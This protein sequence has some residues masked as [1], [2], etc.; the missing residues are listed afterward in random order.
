MKF[1]QP[2]SSFLSESNSNWRDLES[3]KILQKIGYTEIEENK[4]GNVKIK[5][6]EGKEFILTP[7][8]Y[9][10]DPQRYGTSN[11]IVQNYTHLIK[12]LNIF[13][14]FFRY[15]LHKDIN[16]ISTSSPLF[17]DATREI[18]DLLS[19]YIK[20]PSLTPEQNQFL[21]C[22]VDGDWSYDSKTGLVNI[23]GS[24]TPTKKKNPIISSKKFDLKTLEGLKFGNVSKNFYLSYGYFPTKKFPI[25]SL[26]GLVQ[27][28]GGD[29]K[30]NN[31][32]LTSLDGSPKFVGGNFICEDNPLKSLKGAPEIIKGDF[33]C[34]AFVIPPGEWGMKGWTRAFLNPRVKD[35]SLVVTLM[36]PEEINQMLVNDPEKTIMTLRKLWNTPEFAEVQGGIKVPERYAGELET[37][38]GLSNLGF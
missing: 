16:K 15:F 23:E 33:Y 29:F 2:L 32:G 27:R 22:Y 38:S 6:S 10:R 21:A 14:V 12:S 31:L 13:E 25:T 3:W 19:S 36:N 37:L 9:I 28:V 17:K 4:R 35:K 11:S 18:N 20:D 8:G 5:D 26:G 34:D 24:L 1:I 7:T 30:C